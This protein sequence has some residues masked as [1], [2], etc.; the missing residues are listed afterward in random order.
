MNRPYGMKCGFL[1]APRLLLV[2]PDRDIRGGIVAPY[3]QRDI[4]SPGN[5]LEDFVEL[6]Q[7]AD[8]YVA[9]CQQHI[10]MLQS[11]GA[12]SRTLDLLHQ[13]PAADLE[14]LQLLFAQLA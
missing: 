5:L 8:R 9:D 1:E 4:L 14:L 10:A 7:R 12:R 2:E 13:Q 6:I 3:Q 11:G